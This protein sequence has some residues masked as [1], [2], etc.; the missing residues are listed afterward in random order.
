MDFYNLLSRHWSKDPL[1]FPQL[2][3]FVTR[4]HS[5]LLV[6]SCYGGFE[7]VSFP[8]RSNE[9][10]LGKSLPQNFHV[11]LD[12]MITRHLIQVLLSLVLPK[13]VDRLMDCSHLSTQKQLKPYPIFICSQQRIP[14]KEK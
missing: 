11:S 12:T 8:G 10:A 2:K 6:Y 4:I 7:F 3:G 5:P 9:V 1:I 13:H 14:K